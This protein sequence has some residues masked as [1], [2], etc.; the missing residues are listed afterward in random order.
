M[1]TPQ[2]Q[3]SAP[4][5][6]R[7][8]LHNNG[9]EQLHALYGVSDPRGAFLSA[10]VDS[11]I[12]CTE[13]DR[14]EA[15]GNLARFH[16]DGDKAGSRNGWAVLF[17]DAHGFAGA[18]GS[19]RT[20]Y[21][22]RWHQG[23]EAIT[24]GDRRR[25]DAAIQSAQQARRAEREVV[26]SNAAEFATKTWQNTCRADP[27]HPY[28]VC[29]GAAPYGL[30]QIGDALLVAMCDAAGLVCNLQRIYP[31]G[32]K[33]FLKGGRITGLHSAIGTPDGSHL[34]LCEGWATGATLH[35]ETGFP[36]WC[37]MNCGNLLSV[38]K[39]ARRAFPDADIVVCGDDDRHTD[40]NPGRT[41][42]TAAAIAIGARLA[43]PTFPDDEA[44]TDFNDMAQRKA[45]R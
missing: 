20:G 27:N 30:H 10:I 34:L 25:L 41:K 24:G 40:G 13:P 39:D 38:A 22:R 11:G 28:L 6:A 15:T 7:F 35:A 43:F 17:G 1:T 14:I 33:R 45:A 3:R 44:G 26:Q 16:V 12:A 18:F 19:W 31:D 5:G 9:L 21:T 4:G 23:C 37:A 8:N 32:A 29:K 2:K 36:V 42:A